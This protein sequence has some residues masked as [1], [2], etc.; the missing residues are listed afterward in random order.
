MPF[1]CVWS[2]SP[3]LIRETR[4]SSFLVCPPPSLLPAETLRDA[5]LSPWEVVV[6]ILMSEEKED[7]GGQ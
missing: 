2:E 1:V 7:A 6:L 3:A 4:H 5:Q